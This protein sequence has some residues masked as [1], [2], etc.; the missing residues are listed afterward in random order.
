[1]FVVR[2]FF[3]LI[4][5]LILCESS[6]AQSVR[7]FRNEKN[8]LSNS[9]ILINELGFRSF[10]KVEYDSL[11]RIISKSFYKRKNKLNNFESYEYN[12]LSLDIKKKSI[13]NSDS[14]LQSFTKF[15]IR[16]IIS[17]KFIRYAYD[18]TQVKD[19]D[20]RFTSIEYDNL[21]NPILYKFFDV[22]G[23][24]Y[25]IIEKKYNKSS[26]K[27]RQEDWFLMPS[28]KLIRRY[29]NQFDELSGETDVWE[30]DSTLNVVNKM[31]VDIDGRA[32]IIDLILDIR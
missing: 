32:D 6:N 24:L 4:S 18:I 23:Y 8:F 22:N 9:E 1:M 29:V 28:K 10:I 15:G 14:T 16:E 12:N 13:F 19:Y 20:D 21:N 31:I 3:L 2:S 30:Y 7:Y 25:G 11:D 27:L 17:E 26:N 5:L